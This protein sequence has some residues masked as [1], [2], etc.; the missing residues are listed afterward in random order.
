MLDL[1][2]SSAATDPGLWTGVVL[3]GRY[4]VGRLLGE[5]GMGEAHVARDLRLA[6]TVVVKRPHPALVGDAVER[7][8]FLEEVRRVARLDH[9]HVLKI[10]DA[11]TG[12]DGV[13][14]AVMPYLPGGSLCDRLLAG[15]TRGLRGLRSWLPGVA[16]ALDYVHA[17]GWVHRD[18]KPGNV[19]FDETGN[20]VLADFGLAL[21]LEAD[22][23]PLGEPGTT[24]GS[25]EYMAPEVLGGGPVGPTYD[26]YGLALV[27]YESLAGTLPHEAPTAIELL[28]QRRATA[29]RPLS[30]GGLRV[31]RR[32]EAAFRRALER[33][34]ARRWPTCVDFADAVCN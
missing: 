15:S 22:P 34:P 13:P 21:A 2:R 16:A 18:V 17:R 1:D 23:D 6:R 12:P 19:L 20:G 14:Y 10:L 27:A 5:G 8:R 25:P 24:P 3:D 30:R 26:Q 28:L 33:E 11:G 31:P 7:E 9:P 4:E 32:V 29:P